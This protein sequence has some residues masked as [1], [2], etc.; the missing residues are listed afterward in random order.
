MTESPVQGLPGVA[1]ILCVS[2]GAGAI[3]FYKKAFGAKEQGR[4]L[5]PDGERIMN[6]MLSINGGVVMLN[7]DFPE[8]ADGVSSTPGALGGSPVTIHLQ[9]ENVD[10]AWEQALAAG[11]TIRVPLADAFWGDRFGEVVD[12]YG[13]HWSLATRIAEPTQEEMDEAIRQ[14]AAGG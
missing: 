11:A 10:A 7:D 14:M 6:A 2:D 9:V 5:G 3:E 1:P 4:Q 13:H 8:F 12:P